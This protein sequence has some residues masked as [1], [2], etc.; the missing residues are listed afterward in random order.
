MSGMQFL[1]LS[2]LTS[3][4]V[5]GLAASLHHTGHMGMEMGEQLLSSVVGRWFAVWSP[6]LG[7]NDQ[8]RDALGVF[9]AR[10]I[11]AMVWHERRPLVHGFDSVLYDRVGLLL[12]SVFPGALTAGTFLAESNIYSGSLTGPVS[13]SGRAAT[14]S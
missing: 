12:A 8:V 3:S 6:F 11:L 5:A 2:D 10:S 1:T 7:L 9:L 13:G 4:L 14:G